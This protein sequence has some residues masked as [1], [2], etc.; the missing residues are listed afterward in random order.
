MTQ[1]LLD[2]D[3]IDEYWQRRY[4]LRDPTATSAPT[5]AEGRDRGVGGGAVVPRCL[6]A[7]KTKILLAGKYLNVVR[8]CGIDMRTDA[9]VV[10]ED[11]VIDMDDERCG[12]HSDSA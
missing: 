3:Y 12:V 11:E 8:E 4:T 9:G 6:E 2:A 10:A 7:W 1:A 5:R